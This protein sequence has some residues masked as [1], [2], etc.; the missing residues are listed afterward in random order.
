[1]GWWAAGLE[2]DNNT[3]HYSLQQPST[4]VALTLKICEQ[5]MLALVTTRRLLLYGG[6]PVNHALS[7]A[8][9]FGHGSQLTLTCIVF[10]LP[11]CHDNKLYINSVLIRKYLDI[12]KTLL[13]LN[14][15][16]SGSVLML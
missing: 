13:I 7:R 8:L 12:K 5:H 9:P 15:T 3:I 11:A 6:H 14:Q 16:T 4:S 2:L 10:L 1:M